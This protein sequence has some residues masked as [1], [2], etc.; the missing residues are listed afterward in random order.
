MEKLLQKYYK[1]KNNVEMLE[2][3]CDELKE[4]ILE[5]E[6]EINAASEQ[7]L[8]NRYQYFNSIIDKKKKIESL[9]QKVYERLESIEA[10]VLLKEL[11]ERY[12]DAKNSIPMLNQ[13]CND[14]KEMI[15]AINQE[16]NAAS[17]E[18]LKNRYKYFDL[19]SEKQFKIKQLYQ[20]AYERRVCLKR[21][22][23][24]YNSKA[25]LGGGIYTDV[26]TTILKSNLQ[27]IALH[28][29]TL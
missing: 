29:I 24:N 11:L 16:I 18:K 19:L 12:E 10:K 20:R 25:L 7:E 2:L 4:M 3:L 9:Y 13:L 27:H 21:H 5:I 23:M 14:L 8:K 17:D 6:Q 15:H 22:S 1:Y 26:H 28:G